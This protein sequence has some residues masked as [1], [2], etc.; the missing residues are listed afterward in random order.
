MSY[1]LSVQNGSQ[2]N[3]SHNIRSEKTIMKEPHINPEGQFEIWHDEKEQDAY[4]RLFGLSVKRYNKKQTRKCRQISSYYNKVKN[5]GQQ[6]TAYE[7]IITVGNRDNKPDDET[8]KK[9]LKEYC[10]TWKQRNPTLELIG[11]YYH[12]DELDPE[13]GQPS[14]PHV[15]ID[16][17]PV[18]DGYKNGM[19]TRTCLNRALESMG[20]EKK[21]KLTPQIQWQTRERR[22]LEGICRSMGVEFEPERASARRHFS[23]AT[24]IEFQKLQRMQKKVKETDELLHS[25]QSQSDDLSRQLDDK[26]SLL[27]QINL[28]LERQRKEKERQEKAVEDIKAQHSDYEEALNVPV[29]KGFLGGEKAD[30]S[31]KEVQALKVAVISLKHDNVDLLNE[32]EDLKSQIKTFSVRLDNAN[33]QV[34]R[35][36]KELDAQKAL[37]I[38][39]QDYSRDVRRAIQA[40]PY[41][42]EAVDRAVR[43]INR[44][45]E[46]EKNMWGPVSDRQAKQQ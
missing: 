25:K 19:E 27:T 10:D 16:Y 1:T 3:R 33:K 43:N 34:D 26:N 12:A 39:D 21:G 23:K 14:A 32:N 40:D 4:Q 24:Y 8:G 42:E 35:L 13:T 41:L 9:I 30:I 37:G 18:A 6:H 36:Q 31:V 7:V 2:C 38:W 11:A 46:V 45:Q 17:V 20:F 5:S 28:E 15:H 22:E 44:Q 29:R